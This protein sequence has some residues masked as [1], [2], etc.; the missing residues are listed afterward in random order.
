M[1]VSTFTYTRTHTAAFV[2]DHIRNQLNRIIQAAGLSPAQLVDD[3][4]VVGPAVRTWLQ[5]GHL[6][7]VTIEFFKPGS[8]TLQLRWDF[9]V[10]YDG[11]GVDD[12]M[13]VDRDHV[14]RT[15]DKVGR[16]PAGCVYRIIL[17][18]QRGRPDVAGMSSAS[19]L[20]TTG[21]VSRSTGTAIAT[22]DITAGLNYWR[23]A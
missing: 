19:H 8:S 1:A 20:A 10:T 21:L 6:K 5:S 4:T 18:S 11:S 7:V 16:P 3:W 13:W 22:H 15:I 23:P 17:T 2:A 9:P 12:D 14:Q